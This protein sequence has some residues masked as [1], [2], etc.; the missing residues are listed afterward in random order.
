[1]R[2]S[3]VARRARI[4]KRPPWQAQP[5]C[6]CIRHA[7]HGRIGR[8]HGAG[9]PPLQ[10]PPLVRLQVLL[11]GR[12]RL[13]AQRRVSSAEWYCWKR[14]SSGG[15]SVLPPGRA[16]T[17][18]LL[19]CVVC[20]LGVLKGILL[21]PFIVL[22]IGLG[23]LIINSIF[24]WQTTDYA[25]LTVQQC[26]SERAGRAGAALPVLPHARHRPPLLPARYPLARVCAVSSTSAPTSRS[27]CTSCCRWPSSSASCSRVR[28]E[29][30]GS[31]GTAR[32]SSR[33]RLLPPRRVH[34]MQSRAGKLLLG[35][36]C[37]DDGHD[38]AASHLVHSACL[39]PRA[40]SS[41]RALQ[42]HWP[43]SPASRWRSSTRP[44]SRWCVHACRAE[45]R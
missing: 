10:P 18:G 4:T 39:P 19:P 36:G 25:Y 24:L 12:S 34:G 7:V 30:M 43:S 2:V 35:V 9:P 42:P 3:H 28:D 1:M 44:I 16:Q 27:R 38:T 22:V 20:R 15:W 29:G 32:R 31:E 23:C 8:R 41:S 37:G 33:R 45:L 5:R 40:S 26:V 21:L 17:G 13:G 11:Q 6:L 14:L